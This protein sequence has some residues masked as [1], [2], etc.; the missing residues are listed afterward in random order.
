M[1][2]LCSC[3]TPSESAGV[4]PRDTDADA[5]ADSDFGL[6]AHRVIGFLGRGGEGETWLVEDKLTGAISAAKL[7]KRPIPKIMLALVARE[8]QIQS[9]HLGH[10]HVNIVSAHEVLLTHSHLAIMMEHVSGG[11]MAQYVAGSAD[12]GLCMAEDE[13]RYYFL[14]VLDA[15]E[16]C[17]EHKVAHR[18]LK[19]DNTLLDGHKPAWIKLCDFGFSKH[20]LHTSNMHTMRIGTPEYM[21]PELIC[22][23]TG[24]D[25]VKA[26]VWAAGVMLYVMLLG[27][28]PFE[29]EQEQEQEQEHAYDT[30]YDIWLQQIKTS[31]HDD[32]PKTGAA[33]A[34]L[35]PELN[36]LLHK[37]LEVKQAD[38]I[39]VAGIRAHPWVLKPLPPIYAA[40]MDELAQ[41]QRTD[42]QNR[43]A[44]DAASTA[45]HAARHDLLQAL[46]D[47]ANTPGDPS[48]DAV[49][50]V[51]LK[52]NSSL[53]AYESARVPLEHK[54]EHEH[55][56]S[57]LQAY[58]YARVQ[59][60]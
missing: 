2:G 20:W 49:L 25:G 24:Y 12:P 3:A 56:H 39:G 21:G 55:E 33:A 51:P 30:L 48:T 41:K 7:I 44:H 6:T 29:S 60:A 9:E 53:E 22:S 43:P 11:N 26:D 38:R 57:S 47:R 19:L 54:H 10:G 40:A 16:Y 1:G 18:D 42:R 27:R 13:A 45:E 4:A 52:H 31:W 35:T 59:I 37:M 58:E 28:F 46:L 34:L 15:L 17:H 23:R 50:R 36:D 8:I 5:D 32:L 14:Q